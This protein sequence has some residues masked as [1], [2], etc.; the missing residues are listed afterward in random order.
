M[1]PDLC[2]ACNEKGRMP[3]VS[4]VPLMKDGWLYV[5]PM[6]ADVTNDVMLS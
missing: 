1:V 6:C 4:P 3:P 2:H 5:Q